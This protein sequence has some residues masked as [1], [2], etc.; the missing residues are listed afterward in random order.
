LVHGRREGNFAAQIHDSLMPNTRAEINLDRLRRNARV[1][2]DAAPSSMDVMAVVKANA[3]GHGAPACVKAL[4]EVGVQY[5]AVATL[6]EAERLRASGFRGRLMVFAPP[7][8][9]QLPAYERLDADLNLV[10]LEAVR[11]VASRYPHLIARAHLKLDT[12]MTRLGLHPSELGEA[13]REIRNTG[14]ALRAVWTHLALSSDET[15]SDHGAHFRLTLAE[16]GLAGVARH[17]LATDGFVDTPGLRHVGDAWCRIGVGLYGVQ[18]NRKPPADVLDPVMRFTTR[19]LQVRTVSAGT[20][21]SYHHTWR[22]PGETQIATV[23]AGYADGLP[24]LLSNR[25]YVGIV[26]QTRRFPIVGNICMD[27]FMIDIGR[28]EGSRPV[29]V[30]DKVVMFGDGGPSAE[31]VAGWAE[32]ITYEV[33]SGI[34]SRV[35]RIYVGDESV[36]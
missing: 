9:E 6:G 21:V 27:M 32:T 25:G 4:E 8:D 15:G 10:S 17:V 31:E 14:F 22:A 16:A 35:E 20:G 29:M 11:V 2:M 19:V 13:E 5:F 34:G 3:Y 30:G 23:G 12:G 36:H 7:F 24:R 26:G 18:S 33:C 28:G 1:F